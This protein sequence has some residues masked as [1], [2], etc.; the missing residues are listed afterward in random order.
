MPRPRKTQQLAVWMNAE[1][2]G[3][4]TLGT[5]NAHTFA[6]EESWLDAPAS[7]P[8][9]LS[10]PLQPSGI[11]YR[12]EIVESFFDN[13]LP[14][15]RDIRRRIQTRFHSASTRA[16][17]LLAEI[18]R[19]CVGAVQLLPMDMAPTGL[20]R[21]DGETLTDA[22]VARLLRGTPTAAFP[23]QHDYDDFRISLAGAQEKTALLRHES[24]WHRPLGATPTTHIFKL[25]LGRVGNMQADFTT[26]VE[27]EWLCAQI[28]AAF[29]LPVAVC[30]IAVFEDQK[31]LIV[32]RFD[33][34]MAQAGTHW[35]RLPQEDCCQALG[36]PPAVKYEADGG[37]G[38]KSILDL[39][40]GAQDA[41]ADRLTFFK[42]QLV[43]WLLCATDGHAK[44]FS[45]AIEPQGRYR[46]TP[47]YDVLSA[48]PILGRGTNQLA[49]E[50]ARMAMAASGQNRH[51]E[52]NRIL[53][54][55][56]ISTA[57]ACGIS[58]DIAQGMID[59]LVA[60]TPTAIEKVTASL[61]TTFPANVADAIFAGMSAAARKLDDVR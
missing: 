23:G 60:S 53:R 43:F 48:Y 59:E 13:L 22:D 33:R 50:R 57:R 31:A 9:S 4:W 17:D 54:R 40:L 3:T 8:L 51:Y 25:P 46:L 55:H 61:P 47:L 15:N 42:A 29:G 36:V 49:P 35:L 18:G 10:M 20:D 32:E 37:P 11:P 45:L 41:A 44:N 27:N 56:W 30:E 52:W 16:F 5:N 58:E 14:D 28:V 24:S 19:D 21:I 34:R 1:R 2:V 6:Y 7:R 12:D 26:S 39:L 38:I